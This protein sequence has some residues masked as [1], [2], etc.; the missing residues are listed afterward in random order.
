MLAPVISSD[1]HAFFIDLKDVT[2]IYRGENRDIWIVTHTGIFRLIRTIGELEI[3]FQGSRFLRIDKEMILNM[4]R[5]TNFNHELDVVYFEPSGPDKKYFH[6][7]A[8]ARRD[9]VIA[10]L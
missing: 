5:V 6:N 2:Y 10:A 9:E 7:V 1:D 4:D 8:R 3:V